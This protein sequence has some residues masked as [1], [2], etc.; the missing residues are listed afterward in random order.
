M[1]AT[2]SLASTRE[3][4]QQSSGGLPQGTASATL[5]SASASNPAY[6]RQWATYLPFA[7]QGP[8]PRQRWTHLRGASSR[9][10][11]SWGSVQLITVLYW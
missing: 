7:L 5:T 2:H 4:G 3:R 9:V 11:R 8:D 6:I 1:A 10:R